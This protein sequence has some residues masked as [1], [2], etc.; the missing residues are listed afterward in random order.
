[1]HSLSSYRFATSIQFSYELL[2]V[3]IDVETISSSSASPVKSKVFPLSIAYSV[4]FRNLVVES[5]I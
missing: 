5:I 3:S 2:Y 4:R 1:M